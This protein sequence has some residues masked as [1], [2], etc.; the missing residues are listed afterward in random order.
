MSNQLTHSS[1][2]LTSN[3][4][5]VKASQLQPSSQNPREIPFHFRAVI[6]RSQE[7]WE[8]SG[9]V[10]PKE[11]FE[12]EMQRFQAVKLSEVSA[13]CSK[14]SLAAAIAAEW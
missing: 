1:P 14:E 8:Q 11:G 4:G 12:T 9:L 5:M 6:C 3:V 13:L 2:T 7:E 10:C